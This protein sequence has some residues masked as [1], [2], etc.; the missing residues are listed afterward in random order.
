LIK[1]ISMSLIPVQEAVSHAKKS[2][3]ELYQDDPLKELALEE[4]ELVTEGSR[5]LWSVTLGFHRSKSVSTAGGG[6]LG[7]TNLRPMPQI[8]N[9]VYKTVFIDASTGEFVKMDM[10]QVQ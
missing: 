1:E 4:I 7:L 2:L 10:R 8:E 3:T 9:R 5:N 6:V